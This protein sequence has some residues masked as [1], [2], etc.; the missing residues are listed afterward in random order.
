MDSFPCWTRP[1]PVSHL[2]SDLL[3]FDS[4]IGFDD[5]ESDPDSGV[6]VSAQMFAR[7]GTVMSTPSAPWRRQRSAAPV[8][9]TT[10]EMAG[11]A[12]PE[13][14]AWRTTEDVPSTPLFVSSKDPTRLVGPPEPGQKPKIKPLFNLTL[15]LSVSPSPAVSV[16]PACRL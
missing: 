4:C 3:W 9:P 11:S 13:T 10:R 16:C 1:N 14:P 5:N 15:C 2:F 7:R 12:S 8:R 6:C